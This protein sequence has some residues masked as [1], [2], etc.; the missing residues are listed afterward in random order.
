MLEVIVKHFKCV[1]LY[2]QE[3]CTDDD[4]NPFAGKELMNLEELVA[5][6]SGKADIDALMDITDIDREALSYEPTVDT[7][8]SN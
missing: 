3:T 1:G 2:P 7:S 4:D 8:D 5:K 6:V